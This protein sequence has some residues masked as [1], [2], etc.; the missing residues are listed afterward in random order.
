V[1]LPGRP[2]RR[3]VMTMTFAQATILNNSDQLDGFVT[4]N[5]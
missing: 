1:L 2:S 4:P 5:S 3:V